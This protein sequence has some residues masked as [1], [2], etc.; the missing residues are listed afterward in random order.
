MSEPFVFD[1]RCI[2]C[3]DPF[4]AVS[5]G[6]M[7]SFHCR[8][9]AKEG[10][11]HCALIL[12]HEFSGRTQTIE[13]APTEAAADRMHF[14]AAVLAPQE[15]DLIWYHFSFWRDDGSGCVLDK[16]GYRSDEPSAPWQMTVYE[17]SRTPA[18]FG[19]GV[20]YQIFPDRFCRLTDPHPEGLVGDRWI[21]EHWDDIHE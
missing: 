7:V 15:P 14:S 19:Q 21:Q 16:T 2:L 8:P 9:L 1:P 5:C 20:T 3:K 17:E 6:T 12:H 13:L 4:G 18:W 11:T 10:F